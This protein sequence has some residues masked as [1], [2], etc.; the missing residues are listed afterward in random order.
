LTKK[1]PKSPVKVGHIGGTLQAGQPTSV[2]VPLSASAA[3]HLT[4]AKLLH[5]TLRVS[6]RGKKGTTT[7]KPVTKTITLR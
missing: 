5:T 7:G 6:V 1:T 3:K 2:T 4:H